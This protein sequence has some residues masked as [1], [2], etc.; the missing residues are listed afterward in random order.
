MSRIDDVIAELTSGG[1]REAC[2]GEI[3]KFIRGR[4][5]TKDDIVR[6]GIPSI[7]YGEIYTHYGVAA[8]SAL[9][10]VRRDLED[11]LRFARPGD[12]IIAAVGETVEDVAK[13]VAWLGAEP[14]AIHDDTF[15]F[16]S[17]LNPTFVSYFMRTKAFHVQKDRYVARAK[18]K[19]L[20]GESLAKIR[21][22]VPPPKVQAEIVKVLDRF[23]ELKEELE[24]GLKAE[25]EARRRQFAFYKESLLTFRDTDE[26]RRIPMGDL[27][28]WYGG[29]T[30]SKAVREYW[31]DAT[32]PWLS[33]KDMGV[34][35]VMSTVDRVAQIALER[36]AL[37][38]VP[39]GSIAFVVRS[40][41]LRRHLPIAFVPIS[42][43]LNQDMRALIPR[44]DILPAYVAQV[45]QARREEILAIAGRTDGSMA[46]IQSKELMAYRIPVPSLVEQKRIVAVLDKF[47]AFVKG[48]SAGLHAEIASRR[49]QYE[50]YRDRLLTFE[51]AAA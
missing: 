2:M 37:K 15:L 11:R 28:T 45:C 23:S 39:P 33:P 7:H 5:F 18:V 50:Y 48:L 8:T 43:T 35:T 19:R 17:A 26:V 24:V 42:V 13:A 20:S 44:D 51:E 4:R 40:N 3:G 9:S 47:D 22:P 14:V 49:R 10:H 29:G 12:V 27:G 36:T 16:R 32:I 25:L 30:P 6:D 38:L 31:T 1:V 34:D 21:I 46:A 41:I